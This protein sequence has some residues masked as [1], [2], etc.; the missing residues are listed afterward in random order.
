MIGG[1]KKPTLIIWAVA[2]VLV[3]SSC[4][5]NG[6]TGPGSDDGIV[7]VVLTPSHSTVGIDETTVLEATVTNGR[8]EIVQVAIEWSSSDPGIAFV[9][10]DVGLVRGVSPGTVAVSATAGGKVGMA[11]VTVRLL[12]EAQGTI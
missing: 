6:G 11:S 8:G 3:T 1:L 2:A 9:D 12:L 10:Q 7:S 4:G 5:P